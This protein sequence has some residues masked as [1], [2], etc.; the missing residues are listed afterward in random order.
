MQVI[1]VGFNFIFST[2]MRISCAFGGATSTSS[3]E[4]GLLASHNTAA[5]HLITCKQSR[6]NANGTGICNSPHRRIQILTFLH[7]KLM[8]IFGAGEGKLQG[9]NSQTQKA[10]KKPTRKHSVSPF[11][12]PP[13][14][15]LT[16]F[17]FLSYAVFSNTYN[18]LLGQLDTLSI[19]IAPSLLLTS[20][21]NYFCRVGLWCIFE[22][23]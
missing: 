15:C 2:F 10:T 18:S 14:P 7:M 12:P 1:I 9:K 19:L 16:L 4:N 17:I 21:E 6:E 20:L 23:S 22:S 3:I 13:R 11:F 8:L 5:L